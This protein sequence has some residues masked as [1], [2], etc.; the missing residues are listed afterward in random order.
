MKKILIALVAMLSLAT[1]VANDSMY[2]TSGSQLIPINASD[3]RLRS[4]VLT[5]TIQD[6]GFALV[7]VLYKI[8][9]PGQERTVTM[10]FEA[11]PPYMGEDFNSQGVH[12]HINNFSV[13]IN[14]QKQAY[15]NALV[16]LGSIEDEQKISPIDFSQWRRVTGADKDEAELR[17]VVYNQQLDSLADYAYAYYFEANFKPGINTIHHTYRYRTGVTAGEA[18]FFDYKLTPALRWAGR[19]IDD[20]TLNIRTSG[21]FKHF[22]VFNEP[23]GDNPVWTIRGT[24]KQQQRSYQD[25]EFV[26]EDNWREVTRTAT[27]LVL[28]DGEAQ[29]HAKNFKPQDELAIRSG[30]TW[31][32]QSYQEGQQNKLRSYDPG[33]PYVAAIYNNSEYYLVGKTKIPAKRI[34][35][36]LP[37]ACRGYVFKD[38][39]LQRFF[40]SQFWY[41]PDPTYKA[42][43][44]A[45]LPIERE[46]I[47]DIDNPSDE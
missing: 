29:F 46:F 8:D 42:D 4:E 22:F 25:D 27:E 44:N 20:F 28:R 34:H 36:N 38:K 7:D 18:F 10:G 16:M 31:R 40:S 26:G 3:L 11:D 17:A 45:L 32:F 1:A 39:N 9:N 15:R 41:I 23:F 2:Y 24:G 14:G 35:R 21:T 37:F 47:H 13:E 30:D 33:S 19:Q 43:L 6:D 12:P 5:I